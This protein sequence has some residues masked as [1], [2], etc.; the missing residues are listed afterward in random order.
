MKFGL[1]IPAYL[2]LGRTGVIAVCLLV[3]QGLLATLV[4]T[5]LIDLAQ[6]PVIGLLLET[7]HKTLRL[8]QYLLTRLA[9]LRDKWSRRL[10]QS[11]FWS[12]LAR[13]RGLAVM[14]VSSL[15]LRGCGVISATILS[16]SLG[17]SRVHGTVLV[18]SGSLIGALVTLAVLKEPMR[19]LHGF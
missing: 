12:A 2:A 15:P 1:L 5:L 14:T 3:G 13:N 16:F 8:N 17:F 6:I 7:S 18:M 19:M 11:K 9:R 4:I 10:E